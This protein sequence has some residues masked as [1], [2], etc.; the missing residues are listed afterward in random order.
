[1][2]RWRYMAFAMVALAAL[3]VPVRLP[4]QESLPRK[5]KRPKR[6][7]RRPRK[8][9]APAPAPTAT[10][11]GPAAGAAAKTAP[12]VMEAVKALAPAT[13]AARRART[14]EAPFQW[15]AFLHD[16]AY[17][18]PEQIALWMILLV[19]IAGLVYAIWLVQKVL[20][21]DEGDRA[22]ARSRRG[23]FAGGQRL[24]GETVPRDHPA[25]VPAHGL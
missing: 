22:D 21:A 9:Q 3:A 17:D 16:K 24:P 2:Q 18:W 19:A 8:V 13:P 11:A 23:D 7:R 4:A 15:F 5:E 20:E 12:P 10:K 25:G 6:V 14:Q 1:M